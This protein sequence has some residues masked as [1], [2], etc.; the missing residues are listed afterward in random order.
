M[1]FD[2]RRRYQK[3]APE[4]EERLAGYAELGITGLMPS[5]GLC[6]G[7]SLRPHL[8]GIGSATISA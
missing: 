3:E 1:H 8:V 6:R 7:I 2:H 4:N 5:S